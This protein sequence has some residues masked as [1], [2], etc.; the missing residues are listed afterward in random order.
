MR[1]EHAK[2]Q[3]LHPLVVPDTPDLVACRI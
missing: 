3:V 2:E 1:E